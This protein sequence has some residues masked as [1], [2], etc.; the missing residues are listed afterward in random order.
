M[1]ILPLKMTIFMQDTPAVISKR[2]DDMIKQKMHL[3]I[4]G[5]FH[6]R[7]SDLTLASASSLVLRML[8]SSA[9]NATIITDFVFATD[10]ESTDDHNLTMLLNAFRSCMDRRV[11]PIAAGL[12][13]F[14]IGHLALDKEMKERIISKGVLASLVSLMAAH[15]KQ[16]TIQ[17]AC[18]ITLHMLSSGLPKDVHMMLPGYMGISGNFY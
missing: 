10:G 18:L 9:A 13:I 11:E 1:K 5:A 3:G 17:E 4:F 15:K 7:I 16:R 6:H 12:L 8:K 14:M 2:I